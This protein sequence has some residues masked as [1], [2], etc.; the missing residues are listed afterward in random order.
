MRRLPALL[1]ALLGA[2]GASSGVFAQ[3][4]QS[5]PTSDSE[6]LQRRLGERFAN[7]AMT[8]LR[9]E[10]VTPLALETAAR[11]M[12]LAASLDPDDV[13]MWRLT[14]KVADLAEIDAIQDKAV[15][16]IVRLDPADDV[17]RL[18]RVSTAVERAQ[19]VEQRTSVYERLLTE[20]SIEQ[21]G[22][23]VASRL[24]FDYALLLR[25]EGRISAF[26]EQ[27][28]RAVELD[29]SNRAAAS[30][31]TGF[32]QSNV[33]DVYAEAELMLNLFLAD[34]STVDVQAAL[35]QLAI[36]VGAYN[37]AARMY[38]LVTDSRAAQGSGVPTDLVA[39]H[40][41]A[42]WGA[43]RVNQA[44]NLIDDEQIRSNASQRRRALQADEEK[45]F[46]LDVASV[47]GVLAPTIATVRAAILDR[48]DDPHAPQAVEVALK[49]YD[50]TLQRYREALEQQRSMS[51]QELAQQRGRYD[52]KVIARSR[53]EQ[54]WVAVW[55]NGDVD[56]AV[57]YLQQ[58]DAIEPLN[59]AARMRFEGWFAVRRGELERGI[60]LL[61]SVQQDDPAA[62]LGLAVARLQQNRT[63]DAARHL[64]NVARSRAGTLMGAWS[65]DY[66]YELVG[67]RVPISDTARRVNALI[68]TLP[69][70]IDRF[71][72]RPSELFA[73]RVHTSQPTF[74]PH[75]PIICTIELS[76]NA[77]FPLG[78]SPEGPI[79]PQIALI[80][81]IRVARHPRTPPLEPIVIDIDQ[82]LRLDPGERVTVNVDLRRYNV[83]SLLESYMILGA[84]VRMKALW[85][86]RLSPAGT[87]AP[88][89]LGGEV[90][91]MPVRVDGARVTGQW[92]ERTL[93]NI[94]DID[95]PSDV[96]DLIM[97]THVPA[98][99]ISEITREQAQRLNQESRTAAV[100]AFRQLSPKQ[101]ALVLSEMALSPFVGPILEHARS[102]D[103]RLVQLAYLLN[104]TRVL[105]DPMIEVGRRSD[106]PLIRLV[107]RQLDSVAAL[108]Q[109]Q[110]F[111]QRQR[112]QQQQGT[113]P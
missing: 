24:A 43:G 29:P 16:E 11:L 25:R 110:K 32:F 67:G 108:Q 103:H 26:T 33:D 91:V 12:E 84:L 89:L 111:M 54:A 23:T 51:E 7:S 52:P 90:D 107:A 83:G 55:L 45:R 78:I 36:G 77:Q 40:V 95:R 20:Q 65:A 68:D 10:P 37:G 80:P 39:D 50:Q 48:Q 93:D 44:L 82:R 53:L 85:N 49:S 56:R 98:T 27:L 64:L 17:A 42:L 75:E 47:E 41:I 19:T 60:E 31:A 96:N 79:Q 21:M 46:P 86:F 88:G 72:R 70:Y 63:R 74:G 87:L 76:N 3:S 104:C 6:T 13:S 1:V 38:Q 99:S 14:L 57:E 94:S 15:R 8:I 73:V 97:L 30:M 100:E 66:L 112:Q 62:Q 109:L 61:D 22:P 4:S 28:S 35:A 69:R 9:V 18:R 5:S 113:S 58:A 71:P 81:A 92:L 2:L 105:D 102:S 106:D 101:Q 59:E 34:P